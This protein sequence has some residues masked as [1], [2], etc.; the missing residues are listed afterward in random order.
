M[1][2]KLDFRYLCWVWYC[3][4]NIYVVCVSDYEVDVVG[5]FIIG[6]RDSVIC[7]CVYMRSEVEAEGK[8]DMCLRKIVVL[9]YGYDVEVVT[10]C[11]LQHNCS[12]RVESATL[13]YCESEP[14]TSIVVYDVSF[15]LYLLSCYSV[16]VEN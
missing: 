3:W 2:G 15:A 9:Y 1:Y 6:I 14:V 4:Y 16:K 8:V 13:W 10:G 12:S 5:I 7:L 11:F